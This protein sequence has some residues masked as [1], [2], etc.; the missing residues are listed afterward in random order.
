M[1]QAANR[2]GFLLALP[3]NLEEVGDMLL[4]NIG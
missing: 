2:D 1:K 4:R 3:Y